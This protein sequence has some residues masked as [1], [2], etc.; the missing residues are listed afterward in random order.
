MATPGHPRADSA[1]GGPRRRLLR[2]VQAREHD[3][4][5]TQVE[6]SPR[7]NPLGALDTNDDRDLMDPR[8]Q[9]L[10]DQRVLASGAV[11]EVDYQP[12]EA[13]QSA[14]FGGQYRAEVDER[15]KVGS[16]TVCGRERMSSRGTLTAG[17]GQRSYRPH[18]RL[19]VRRPRPRSRNSYMKS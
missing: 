15:P 16:L 2:A 3:A 17:Q 5:D 13:R 9:Y 12:I 10:P 4:G 18:E 19:P 8:R 11:F 1:G 14:G 6:H 7:A